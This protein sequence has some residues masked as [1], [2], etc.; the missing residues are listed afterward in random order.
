MTEK[1][2]QVAGPVSMVSTGKTEVKKEAFETVVDNINMTPGT[3]VEEMLD[4][5]T[6]LI[7][8]VDASGSMG[9]G[10]LSEDAAKMY[11][12]DAATLEKYRAAIEKS[13]RQRQ[14]QTEMETI[15]KRKRTKRKKKRKM[16]QRTKR[17]KTMMRRKKSLL[18]LPPDLSDEELKTKIVMEGLEYKFRI[19]LMRN[20]SYTAK[21]S[22]QNAGSQGSSQG[23][24]TQTV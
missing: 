9:E 17:K 14:P 7:Y 21:G 16:S 20:Y 2:F 19:P 11:T 13:R 10:M 22:L 12:W 23:V 18:P 5:Y 15:Q 24:R 8:V 4:H 3:T 1:K 6:R